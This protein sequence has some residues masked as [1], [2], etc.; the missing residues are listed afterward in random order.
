M[1]D[2]TVQLDRIPY[3]LRRPKERAPARP[4]FRARN[5]GE[6]PASRP[7]LPAPHTVIHGG[8]APVPPDFLDLRAEVTPAA[9]GATGARGT[10]SSVPRRR[11]LPWLA[12]K[13]NGTAGPRAG[14]VDLTARRDAAKGVTAS[15]VREDFETGLELQGDRDAEED[16]AFQV[17]LPRGVIRQI[18]LRAAEDGT[19]HRA[20]V[21]RAL[22]AAG[23]AIPEGA[24]VDRRVAAAKRRQQ[25]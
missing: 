6:R 18:R 19:T 1:H 5:G 7:A 22:R 3:F 2:S 25:A 4:E 8:V 17:T 23:L 10:G 14:V 9:D 21:L 11:A 13:T 16:I 24:D 15:G 12:P 20:I